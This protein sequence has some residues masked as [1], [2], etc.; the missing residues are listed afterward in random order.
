MNNLILVR[1]GMS[2]WNKAKRF[3]GWA[4]VELHGQ[5]EAEA[6]IAGKLIKDLQIK[7]DG[8]FTSKLKRA[9]QTLDIILKVLN[10]PNPKINK[11]WELNERH[12]GNLTS[13]NRE[14]IIKKFGEKQVKIWRRSFETRPPPMDLDHP[15][16]KKINT[17]IASESLEDTVNRVIPY[18]E[19]TI[20]PL[21]WSN[22][23]VL[24]VF[25]GNSCRALLMNIFKI[26]KKKIIEFEIP[27]GNPLLIK[28]ENDLKIHN[29]KYLD[30]KRAREILFNI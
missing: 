17:N 9:T 18:Y 12:Y 28:F 3:T 24:I 8:Y 23:N 13:F 25:H 20:K 5:G 14:E 15:Y 2:V 19:K 29:Y 10:I 21:L 26:S 22:K 16:K 7:F 6:K 11:A 27:T 1:H 30:I 4:D